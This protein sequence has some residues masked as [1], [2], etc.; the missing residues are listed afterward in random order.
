MTITGM[1]KYANS[2]F[3]FFLEANTSKCLP[4][5]IEAHHT[6]IAF[7]DFYLFAAYTFD[8]YM[9]SMDDRLPD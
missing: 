5:N 4:N 3:L 9:G 6:Y 1:T 7:L 8:R 2:R